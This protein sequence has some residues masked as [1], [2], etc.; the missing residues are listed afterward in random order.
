MPGCR[1]A[2]AC[3]PH[4]GRAGRP[5]PCRALAVRR[6]RC[7]VPQAWAPR[8]GAQA[9]EDGGRGRHGRRWPVRFDDDAGLETSGVRDAGP[10]GVYVVVDDV[11]AHHRRAVE[12][13]AEILVPP[14]D[15]EYGS[16]D[17]TARDAEGDTW[18]FGT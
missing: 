8:G 11:G 7:P 1:R 9:G 17:C 10:A 16:R 15:R 14:T 4:A 13:G 6:G 18:S 2:S 3:G 12:H 5:G